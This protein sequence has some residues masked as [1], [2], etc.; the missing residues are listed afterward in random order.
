[1]EAVGEKRERGRKG[2]FLSPGPP[3]NPNGLTLGRSLWAQL[4][5]TAGIELET[6]QQWRRM[7]LRLVLIESFK[8]KRKRKR[9]RR[10]S[11]VS[12]SSRPSVAAD[13]F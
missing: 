11:A 10:K 6:L 9:K 3:D 2:F 13:C 5:P 12:F 4:W 8:K 1:M 7:K